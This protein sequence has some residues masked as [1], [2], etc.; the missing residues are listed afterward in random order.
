M[1]DFN[2]MNDEDLIFYWRE[3]SLEDKAELAALVEEV[4]KVRG[5]EVLK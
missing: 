3:L 1:N 4:L 5:Y 2:K